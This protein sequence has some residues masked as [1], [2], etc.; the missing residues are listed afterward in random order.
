MVTKS[1]KWSQ[2][3]GMLYSLCFVGKVETKCHLHTLSSCPD[4]LPSVSKTQ[5]VRYAVSSMQPEALDVDTRHTSTCRITLDQ[6]ARE[7]HRA[8]KGVQN[9]LTQQSRKIF[10]PRKQCGARPT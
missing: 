5:I 10:T 6:H 3:N 9:M 1:F 2:M 4:A 7:Q 8:S